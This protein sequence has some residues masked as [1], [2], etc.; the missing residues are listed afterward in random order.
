MYCCVLFVVVFWDKRSRQDEQRPGWEGRLVLLCREAWFQISE[1]KF[2]SPRPAVEILKAVERP[3]GKV[4]SRCQQT[5]S[6]AP[7]THC[8]WLLG[9]AERTNW[10]WSALSDQPGYNI[11]PLPLGLDFAQGFIFVLVCQ[12]VSRYKLMLCCQRL[13]HWAFGLKF[14]WR[15]KQSVCFLFER[16]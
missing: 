1:G 3:P 16:K 8:T 12:L 13:F 4:V 11:W 2:E 14:L 15:S 7:P 6:G 5:G 10:I 9:R